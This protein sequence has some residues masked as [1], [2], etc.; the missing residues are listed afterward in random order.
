MGGDCGDR[1]CP[2][3]KSFMDSP[4]GDLDGSRHLSS[5]AN[6]VL[7]GSD[8]YVQGTQEE[9][10]AM[11]DSLG[12]ILTQT[13][14]DYAECSSAGVCNRATGEC[15]CFQGFYGAACSRTSCPNDCSGHGKCENVAKAAA[16]DY[17]TVYELWD[18]DILYGCTC[19]P[20][21]S[22]VDC[23]LRLC[24]VGVDP[25]YYLEEKRPITVSVVTFSIYD[26]FCHEALRLEAYPFLRRL[27]DAEISAG[28]YNELRTP[29]VDDWSYKDEYVR[30]GI[31][32]M[33]DATEKNIERRE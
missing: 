22:G 15:D 31:L 33:D 3:G 20:G 29:A 6:T 25:R 14:H 21:Y 16:D 26:T 4:K 23:S 2:F 12:N 24:P 28:S 1:I 5:N 19:D 18:R 13:G 27:S 7:I 17:L 30:R 11:T 9:F 10:P 8:M 32:S